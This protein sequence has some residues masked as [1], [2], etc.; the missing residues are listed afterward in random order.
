[1]ADD[2][3][4]ELS[5]EDWEAMLERDRQVQDADPRNA[6]NSPLGLDEETQSNLTFMVVTAG[7]LVLSILVGG[8]YYI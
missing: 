3:T 1:M 8:W 4:T 6:M 5:D 2:Q 7:F